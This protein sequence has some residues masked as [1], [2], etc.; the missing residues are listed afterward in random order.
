MICKNCNKEYVYKNGKSKEFCSSKCSILW[1]KENY[2]IKE[3][4]IC[5]NCNKEYEYIVG[6]KDWEKEKYKNKV[7]AKDF[8]CFECGLKYKKKKIDET[9][10]ERYGRINVGQFGTEEHN[11]SMMKKYGRIN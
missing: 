2:G 11:N 4:H 9:N 10:L 6:Q 8:C 5:K 3:I 1:K 7:R